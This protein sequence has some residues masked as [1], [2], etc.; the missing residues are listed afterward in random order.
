M[1]I[2]Y[3]S[4]LCKDCIACLKD[5]DNA[6][7]AYEY[8]DFSENLLWLK[9]FLAIRDGNDL[10]ENTRKEGMIGIPCIVSEDGRITLD[11]QVFMDM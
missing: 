6:G 3:G 11:W 1:L 2:I 9:E 5:L 7:V 4:R 8:R 10:F